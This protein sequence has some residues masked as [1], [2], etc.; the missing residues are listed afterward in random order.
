M[1]PAVLGYAAPADGCGIVDIDDEAALY[2]AVA[3]AWVP[4]ELREGD[5]EVE[6]AATGA[7][8]TLVQ[9]GDI[10]G[11]LSSSVAEGLE[12]HA[13][14]VGPLRR[15]DVGCDAAGALLGTVPPG[16][17]LVAVSADPLPDAAPTE[18]EARVLAVLAD[19]R[20]DVVRHLAGTRFRSWPLLDVDHE[21]L[22]RAAALS[23]TIIEIDVSKGR[24]DPHGHVVRRLAAGGAVFAIATHASS[25]AE[26]RLRIDVGVS[27]ARRGW[28]TAPQVAST[29]PVPRLRAH[30]TRGR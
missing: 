19:P 7:L 28:L 11:D 18:H 6:A 22:G 10:V 8:P 24:L 30:L 1:L 21:R 29:W 14:E 25:A 15:V 9:T 27:I 5:G 3:L 26:Q 16:A 13:G 20:V 23:G 4:P 12:W 2:A 17:D